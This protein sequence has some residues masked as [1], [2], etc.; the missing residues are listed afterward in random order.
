M[1]DMNRADTTAPALTDYVGLQRF[2]MEVWEAQGLGSADSLRWM[3][4][5]R[6]GNG[7]LESGAIVEKRTPGRATPRLFVNVPKFAAWL[8]ESDPAP[9]TTPRRPRLTVHR[10]GG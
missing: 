3:L 10:A 5:H 8:A 9:P 2:I 4:R 6:R 7:M 1:T